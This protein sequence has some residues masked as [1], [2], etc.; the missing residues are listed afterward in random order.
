MRR[1]AFSLIELLVTIAIISILASLLFPVLGQARDFARSTVCISNNQQ[2]GTAS[3]LYLQDYDDTFAM[4]IYTPGDSLAYGT[5]MVT[6]YDLMLPYISKSRILQCPAD[7][8]AFDYREIAAIYNFNPYSAL[9]YLSYVPNPGLFTSGCTTRLVNRHDV[10]TQSQLP[11]PSDQPAVYE[12]FLS[13]GL[14][15]P[16]QARH[17]GGVNMVMADCHTH[18]MKLK[19]NTAPAAFDPIAKK[20][21]DQWIIDKGPF[22]LPPDTL[23]SKLKVW[24]FFGIVIDP[25]CSG[26]LSTAC[27]TNPPCY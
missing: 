19:L 20:Y 21:L 9:D 1:T 11:F 6:F 22:R 8:T 17:R 10:R 23:A 12:G 16:V 2:I 4:T 13:A 25:E 27:T 14:D 3:S 7:P 5:Q 24:M 18:F 15:T 26:K